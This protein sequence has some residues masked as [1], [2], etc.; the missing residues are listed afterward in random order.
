[1]ENHFLDIDYGN[2]C[3]YEYSATEKPGFESH[4]NGAG[5][6]SYRK[7]YK[8]GVYGILQSV[9][10]VD[11]KF[12]GKVLSFRMLLEDEIY[13]ASFSLFD[14]RGNYDNRFIEPLIT[15]L[16]NMKKE[17]AYRIYPWAL[18]SD[19]PKKDGTPRMIYG[20]SVKEADLDSMSVLEGVEAKVEPKFKRCKKDED[21]D[22]SIH[23]PQ[24]EF[25]EKLGAWKP[26]AVSVEVKEDFLTELLESSLK[27]LGYNNDAQKSTPVK[28]EPVKEEPAKKAATKTELAGEPVGELDDEDYDAL[29][30]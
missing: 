11:T 4:T 17:Q 9:S 30:F 24:L 20:V 14:Q 29:P 27:T 26:T 23:L 2:M 8:K 16:P 15:M 6:E 25:K 21:F 12:K 22:A 3:F 18:E 7:L 19:T 1:M 10:V 13:L 5:K 28:E